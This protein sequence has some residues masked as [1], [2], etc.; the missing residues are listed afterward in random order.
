MT[1]ALHPSAPAPARD[2]DAERAAVRD[3]AAV[4][5]PRHAAALNLALG[6]VFLAS[7]PLGF[8]AIDA[9]PLWAL[10]ISPW[11][12]CCFTGLFIL[13]HEA[14]HGTLLPGHPRLGHAL[15][16]LFAFAYAFM[17]YGRL[18]ARHAEHHRAPGR[19]TDPD[20]HPS[21]RFLPHFAVFLFRYLR[22]SQLALLVF[23]GNAVGQAGH[24]RAML[25]AYVG[26]AVVSTLIVFTVGIF[27]VHHPKLRAAG[28]ADERHRSVGVDLGGAGSLLAILFF[29]THW[30]HH[31]HPHLTW[32]QLG[33][34]RAREPRWVTP[35]EALRLVR[36]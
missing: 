12:V 30:L 23:A 35:G 32:L 24:T 29:N 16:W 13:A 31:E 9:H 28:V 11:L 5:P 19:E 1:T 18:R 22:L 20:A 26:P 33:L 17:D 2:P 7:I 4:R 14:I 27:L 34:F 8:F 6:A 36:G 3:L 25:C 10:A 21:G 15:G